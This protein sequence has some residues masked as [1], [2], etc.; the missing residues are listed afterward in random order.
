V[1]MGK[2]SRQVNSYCNCNNSRSSTRARIIG[3]RTLPLRMLMH[4][5][6]AVSTTRQQQ[7]QALQQLARTIST[8]SAN[9]SNITKQPFPTTTGSTLSYLDLGIRK[10]MHLTRTILLQRSRY[11]TGIRIGMDILVTRIYTK[12]RW[13]E[14]RS[15]WS[16]NILRMKR[17]TGIWI[18][19]LERVVPGKDGMEENTD[20]KG[21]KE[22]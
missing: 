13:P 8:I 4:R 2:S 12:D 16:W 1:D 17:S 3:T 15:V 9:N 14:G 10:D 21:R 18:R 22:L 5:P 7:Q 11:W 20:R 6:R 19:R